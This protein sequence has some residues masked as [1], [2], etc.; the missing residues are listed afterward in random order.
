MTDP[1]P[2][3]LTGWDLAA[4]EQALRDTAAADIPELGPA[5]LAASLL[6]ETVWRHGAPDPVPKDAPGRALRLVALNGAG[7]LAVRAASS[8]ALLVESGYEADAHAPKRRLTELYARALAVHADATGD[9][10]RRWLENRDH[11]TPART[12][13]K[14]LGDK[15]RLFQDLLG[16]SAHADS[17]GL[18]LL[19]SPP[20][21]IDVPDSHRAVDVRPRR[22]PGH[23]RMLLLN[24]TAETTEMAMLICN[25]HGTPLTVPGP[26]ADLLR[27]V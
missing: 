18:Q 21:W 11:G 9:Q 3:D 24:T 15:A 2:P 8:T 12:V 23:A 16:R 1:T 14:S 4:A 5:R 20:A 26:V 7:A 25:A 6:A 19:W 22:D 27:N 17:R 10:A 13:A